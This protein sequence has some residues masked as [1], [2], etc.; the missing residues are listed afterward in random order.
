MSSVKMTL[1]EVSAKL[2]SLGTAQN[3][4]IYKRHGAGDDLFGVSFADLKKLKK[5][6]K[7]DHDLATKL[8]KT[9]NAD[10]RILA[11]MI[12]D[13]DEMNEKIAGNWIKDIYYYVLVDYFAGLISRTAFSDKLMEEWMRST[14]EFY[15]ACGYVILAMKLKDKRKVKGGDLKRYL[16]TIKKEIQ[17]SP[18]RARYGMNNAVISIGVYN[19]GLRSDAI[20]TA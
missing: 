18:N 5:E 3:I 11:C 8:W 20:L 4:K 9:G 19:K 2:K 7:V 15:R 13:S 1:G 10:S 6:I 12:A 14:R 16:K 17:T